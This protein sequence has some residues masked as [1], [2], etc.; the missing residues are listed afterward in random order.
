MVFEN[1]IEFGTSQYQASQHR[2]KKKLSISPVEWS[3]NILIFLTIIHVQVGAP[4][5][6]HEQ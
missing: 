3:T 5:I 2:D 1:E 4:A 6:Q